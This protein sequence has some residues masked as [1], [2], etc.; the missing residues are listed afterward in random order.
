[1]KTKIRPIRR[2]DG[3]RILE[4]VAALSAHEGAAPPP[5]YEET[6]ETYGF[7][8]DRQFGGFL[9]EYDGQTAGYMFFH[10]AFNVGAGGP[11]LHMID[12]YVEPDFRRRGIGK[13]LIAELARECLKQKGLWVTWQSLDNNDSAMG[14]YNKIGGRQFRAADF[15]LAGQDLEALANS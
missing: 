13:A 14:F 4:M 11:G 5:F 15:E 10:Q 7:G 9:A 8:P 1:M 2:E 12:L 3:P 6:Y